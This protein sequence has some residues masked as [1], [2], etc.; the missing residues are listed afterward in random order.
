[1]SLKGM[2]P[3]CSCGAESEI[4]QRGRGWQCRPCAFRDDSA[5]M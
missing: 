3:K 1:M 2:A 5:G 4:W